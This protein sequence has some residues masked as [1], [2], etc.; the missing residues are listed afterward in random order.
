M[1]TV[2]ANVELLALAEAL[3]SVMPRW[4]YLPQASV[5]T[6][7]DWDGDARSTTAA[8]LIDMSTVFGTPANIDAVL[9]RVSVRDS[10]SSASNSAGYIY[11][12]DAAPTGICTIVRAGGMAND[13]IVDAQVTVATDANGDI[14]YSC[15]AS[16]TNTLDVWIYV[17]GYHLR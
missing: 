13:M 5:L 9:L 16:G 15:V 17:L 10:G 2:P 6:S 3:E 14:Y 1:K 8:T 12:A 4:V 7:T 11:F